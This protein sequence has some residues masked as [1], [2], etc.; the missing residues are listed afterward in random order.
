MFVAD[1]LSSCIFY[2]VTDTDVQK[3]PNVFVR[4]F[5]KVSLMSM[6]ILTFSL[7]STQKACSIIKQ[8]I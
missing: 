3:N 7:G 5:L 2:D 8:V 6:G 1:L 4:H